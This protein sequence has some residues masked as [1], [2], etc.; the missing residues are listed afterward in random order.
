MKHTFKLQFGL[1]YQGKNH[2]QAALK[3]L[4]IGAELDAMAEM[5]ILPELPANAS[6][7]MLAKRQ[8]Q[9]TLI[10][11]SKQLEVDGLPEKVLTADYLLQHLSGADY[12]QIFAE[13][14]SLRAKS[15]AATANPENAVAAE[16]SSEITATATATTA[17]P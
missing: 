12:T 15:T 3:P 4:S 6:E 10:Y 17:K 8:V 7:A 9:E 5:E 11:W 2:V 13:Q 1:D 14:E 16:P